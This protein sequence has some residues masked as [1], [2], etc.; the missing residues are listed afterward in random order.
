MPEARDDFG[1][2]HIMWS[3]PGRIKITAPVVSVEEPAEHQPPAQIEKI[4]P[5]EVHR[6]G[7]A[8]RPQLVG[9][10]RI[11]ERPPDPADAEITC[12][13]IFRTYPYSPHADVEWMLP[14][15]AV[16]RADYFGIAI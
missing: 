5:R 16:N 12:G 11:A 10:L 2:H 9:V 6:V 15:V 1:R 7:P 13:N 3:D 4:L 8:A 14:H